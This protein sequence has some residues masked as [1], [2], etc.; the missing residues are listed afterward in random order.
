MASPSIAADDK[1]EDVNEKSPKV[2]VDTRTVRG[3]DGLSD[4]YLFIQEGSKSYYLMA[5]KNRCIG[6]RNANGIA[7]KNTTSRICSDEF[8]E[9]TFRD[10]GM[11]LRTCRIGKIEAVESKEEAKALIEK[12]KQAK[13]KG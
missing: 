5:M 13:S 8:G 12:K 11:G 10:R 1:D 9:V 7:L 4:E 6:L 2:C 3:F